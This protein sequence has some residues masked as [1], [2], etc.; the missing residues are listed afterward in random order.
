[1]GNLQLK[2]G[3]IDFLISV[4]NNNELCLMKYLLV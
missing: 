3:Q 1:M 4:D 2:G